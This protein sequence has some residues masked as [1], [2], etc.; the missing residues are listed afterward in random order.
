[1]NNYMFGNCVWAQL[2]SN[3]PI[4]QIIYDYTKLFNLPYYKG[5]L[6]L[7]Y[8][9]KEPFIKDK[10][11]VEDLFIDGFPY[12]TLNNGFYSIQQ[13]YRMKK[14]KVNKLHISMAY[15]IDKPFTDRELNLY[16][17]VK[18]PP[19]IKKEDLDVHLWDCNSKNPEKWKLIS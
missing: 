12:L 10:Y 2:Y 4:N 9:L 14:D 19:I 18:M 3:H 8:N 5:H 17:I 7:E 15:K 1:M 6:T 16:E 11:V 13:D